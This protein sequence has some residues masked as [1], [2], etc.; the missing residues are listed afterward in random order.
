VRFNDWG[1]GL[2]LQE[3]TRA[4]ALA[5]GRA[6]AVA[7]DKVDGPRNLARVA[8]ADGDLT[9]AYAHLQRAELLAPGD[10]RSAWIWG[11]VLQENGR[12]AEAA[13]AYRRVLEVFPED[14]SA[15]RNLGRVLYLDGRLEE[16]LAALDR[17]LAIDPED[18]TAHYHRMLVLRALGREEEARLA[19]AAYQY[20]QIDESAAE[21]TRQ[22]RLT[23]PADNRESLALHVHDLIPGPGDGR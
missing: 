15:W 12:Y 18:R 6:A 5:F 17:V 4:A 23:H 9:T 19:E 16:A 1:I 21:V 11:L 7:P 3:D 8:L 14:R 20:Y 10:P 2:L 13:L 22:Y